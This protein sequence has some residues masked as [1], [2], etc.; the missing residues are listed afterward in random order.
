[1][2]EAIKTGIVA[3][4]VVVALFVVITTRGNDELD[5]KGINWGT[6][7]TQEE[8]SY[9]I[10]ESPYNGEYKN[11]KWNDMYV[12][13]GQNPDGTYRAY[14]IHY[15]KAVFGKDSKNIRIRIDDGEL[16]SNNTM[17]FTTANNIPLKLTVSGQRIIVQADNSLGDA[18]IE[19]SYVWRK[20]LSKFTLAEFQ[21]YTK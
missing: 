3:V 2:N 10:A 13:F 1:M 20:G 21:V 12:M 16:D 8:F 9:E 14:F 7:E 15:D 19:G 18:E 4:L 5:L 11:D 17:R 6:I